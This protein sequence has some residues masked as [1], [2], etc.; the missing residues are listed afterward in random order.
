MPQLDPIEN[1]RML[2]AA[3]VLLESR[4]SLQPIADLP[5]DLRPETLE[6]AYALQDQLALAL[7]DIGGWKVGAPSPEATPVFAP[8]PLLGI[9]QSGARMKA[10]LHRLRG[11]E[12]EIAFL[13]GSDLP[14][15]H[16]SYSREEVVA[17]I[18]SCHPVIEILESAF[19]DPDLV[20]RFTLLGDLQMHGG[21]AYGAAIPDWQAIDFSRETAKVSV[22]GA[23]RV[24]ATG[25]NPGGNDLLRVVIWLANQGAPRTGGLRKGDWVTTGSWTGKTL[26]QAGS[27]VLAQFS[28]A[29]EVSLYFE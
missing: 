12:A 21:F 6:S 3:E 18:A 7:G 16:E 24:E 10:S 25:S 19:E 29:G 28:T 8:M 15:R 11:I 4:R 2:R 22:D 23:V 20:E 27:S 5:A 14:P 26:A 9:T 1:D 17:A 13:I